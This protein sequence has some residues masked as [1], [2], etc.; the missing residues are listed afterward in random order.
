[1]AKSIF[2]PSLQD[3]ESAWITQK[4][5][6]LPLKS[7]D[8]GQR[9]YT[10][11]QYFDTVYITLSGLYRSYYIFENQEVNLR[12][13]AGHSLLCPL[14]SLGS[15]LYG[16]DKQ[17]SVESIE[18]VSAGQVFCLSVKDFIPHPKQ[19]DYATH[20]K[21]FNTIVFEHYLSLERRLR[22]IQLKRAKQRYDY[23]CQVMPVDIVHGMPSFHIASYL[24]ITPEALSRIKS[25]N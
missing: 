21:V 8:K 10:E 2:L 17:K 4:L 11:G 13:L 23:F 3:H 15:L 1:M 18:C 5:Q 16:G 14:S 22:M 24:G 12:F 20:L 7:V 25:K 19:N 9:L 6:S